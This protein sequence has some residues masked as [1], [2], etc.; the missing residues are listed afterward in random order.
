MI[1]HHHTVASY[2]GS[3]GSPQ[4]WERRHLAAGNCGPFDE[5]QNAF[6]KFF[7]MKNWHIVGRRYLRSFPSSSE[8]SLTVNRWS[9]TVIQ[10]HDALE[11]AITKSSFKPISWAVAPNFLRF[12]QFLSPPHK[13]NK[14]TRLHTNDSLWCCN[15]LEE[16]ILSQR[17]V[18]L[19]CALHPLSH[20]S[21]YL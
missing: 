15:Q 14:V 6:C 8:Y 5:Q 2:P 20:F 7:L 19:Y 17:N 3:A 16:Y 21:K 11:W 12:K 13:G 18:S 4:T 1:P 9:L 10:H